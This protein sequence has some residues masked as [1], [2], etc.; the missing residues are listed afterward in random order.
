MAKTSV[1]TKT[2]SLTVDHVFMPEDLLRPDWETSQE[3]AKYTG[4]V[5][6]K[7][8][9]YRVHADLADRLISRDQAMEVPPDVT[10]D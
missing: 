7:R 10:E 4:K 2:V 8:V 5:D 6:G 9:K 3:N 1:Q